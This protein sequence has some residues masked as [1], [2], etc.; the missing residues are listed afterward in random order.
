MITKHLIYGLI[1][2]R[3]ERSGEIRYVGKSSSALSRPNKIHSAR[4]RN[5]QVCLRDLGLKEEI[6]VIEEFQQTDN[7]RQVLNDAEVFWIGYF[8]MV[9]ADLTNMTN[10]GDGGIGT[11]KSDWTQLRRSNLSKSLVGKLHSEDHKQKI[12]ESLLGN[13]PWM[14]GKTHSASVKKMISDKLS[15]KNHPNFGKIRDPKIG[16]KVSSKV[17][18]KVIC[19]D[20]GKTFLSGRAAAKFYSVPTSNLSRTLH[21]RTE[22]AG[23]HAFAF[24]TET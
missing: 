15:G 1:D 19:V 9:G 22:H 23:G 3:P 10:G 13:I 7:V 12:R 20:D 11:K 21:G 24:V 16:E 17:S 2:T 4:C 18:R 14:K 5:W 6:F 8:R